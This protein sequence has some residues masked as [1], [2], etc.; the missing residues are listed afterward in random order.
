MGF[1][2]TLSKNLSVVYTLISN[3]NIKRKNSWSE[4]NWLSRSDGKTFGP[5]IQQHTQM[6]A[7]SAQ[8][9]MI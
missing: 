1:K 5:D 4:Y 3:N 6:V 8:D 7:E 2:S 9:V